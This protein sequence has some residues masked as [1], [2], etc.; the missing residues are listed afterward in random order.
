MNFILIKFSEFKMA[1]RSKKILMMLNDKNN[2]QTKETDTN[3]NRFHREG[4]V[5]HEREENSIKNSSMCKDI[6]VIS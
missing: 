5:G 3:C 2:W 1:Y 4:D 6:V